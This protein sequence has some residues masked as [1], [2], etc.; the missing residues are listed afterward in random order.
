MINEKIDPPIFEFEELKEAI[1]TLA[2]YEYDERTRIKKLGDKLRGETEVYRRDT[3]PSRGAA[4]PKN[5]FEKLKDSNKILFRTGG[6][7]KDITVENADD[8]DKSSE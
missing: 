8:P 1:T 2:D 4:R 6:L 3:L 7:F 5:N